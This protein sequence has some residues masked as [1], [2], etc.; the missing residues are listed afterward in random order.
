MEALHGRRD[1]SKNMKCLEASTVKY[2]LNDSGFTDGGDV[3]NHLW[4]AAHGRSVGGIPTGCSP[5][6]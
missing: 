3:E 5:R 2:P 6:V 4:H 1:I